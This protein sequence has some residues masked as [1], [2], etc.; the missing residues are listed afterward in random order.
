[1]DKSRVSCFLTRGVYTTN[2]SGHPQCDTGMQFISEA[3]AAATLVEWGH[4][5]HLLSRRLVKFHSSQSESDGY[6]TMKM[7]K[8]AI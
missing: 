7:I 2:K 3:D 8:V 1:M 6:G 4:F 5:E